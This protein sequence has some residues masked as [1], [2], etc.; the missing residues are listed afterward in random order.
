MEQRRGR[1]SRHAPIGAD[2]QLV[3]GRQVLSRPQHRLRIPDPARRITQQRRPARRPAGA[4]SGGPA[5]TRRPPQMHQPWCP[6]PI[7]TT[8]AGHCLSHIPGCESW[9][10]GA[11]PPNGQKC[12]R[13]ACMASKP[14][15][16]TTARCHPEAP[17]PV[18]VPLTS[19]P[20]PAAV[21]AR[22]AWLR[23]SSPS[24]RS[25]PRPCKERGRRAGCR[26]GPRRWGRRPD[27]R[28][29]D[30]PLGRRRPAASERA[31]TDRH[32]GGC[33]EPLDHGSAP[34]VRNRRESPGPVRTRCAAHANGTSDQPTDTKSRQ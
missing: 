13:P 20:G 11:T 34:C 6:P 8:T 14:A 4:R 16:C 21:L 33:G 15:A 2:G 24:G 19:A 27:S 10:S 25:E 29:P 1:L 23:S 7:G 30:W 28:S 17:G 5:A 9:R 31:R 22:L 32:Y 12:G 3:L 18:W 26:S